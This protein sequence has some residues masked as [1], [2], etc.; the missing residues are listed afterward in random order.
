M[1]SVL[2]YTEPGDWLLTDFIYADA[3]DLN[4]IDWVLVLEDVN[5]VQEL[6]PVFILQVQQSVDDVLHNLIALGY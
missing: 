3:V 1:G 4:A 2:E 6:L 5:V